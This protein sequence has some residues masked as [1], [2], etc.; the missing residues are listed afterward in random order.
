MLAD[1]HFL[2]P[3]WLLLL[4]LLPL[5]YVAFRQLKL[6]DSGWSRLIPARLLSPIIRSEGRS[7]KTPRSPLAPASTALIILA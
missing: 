2:R 3:L 4:L 6:G 7:G 5:M 1:F